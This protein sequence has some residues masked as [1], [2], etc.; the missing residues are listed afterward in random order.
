MYTQCLEKAPPR[1]SPV[2]HGL[3][4]GQLQCPCKQKNE[5]RKLFAFSKSFLHNATNVLIALRTFMQLFRGFIVLRDRKSSIIRYTCWAAPKRQQRT[6]QPETQ[7]M[8]PCSFFAL[9]SFFFLP[10]FLS[11]PLALTCKGRSRIVPLWQQSNTAGKKYEI[12]MKRSL[13]HGLFKRRNHKA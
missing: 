13:H 4:E 2:G 12:S 1:I 8:S 5:T 9:F 10:S 3:P 11:T 6:K 7:K